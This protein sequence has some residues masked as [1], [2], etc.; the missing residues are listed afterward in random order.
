MESQ[1][2]QPNQPN[3]IS[4]VERRIINE[5]KNAGL[6]DSYDINFIYQANKINVQIRKKD[7]PT[8][9]YTFVLDS[10]YPFVPPQNLYLNGVSFWTMIKIPSERFRSLLKKITGKECL[11]C[12]SLMCSHIWNNQKT[13]LLVIEEI[14]K[15]A[16]IK[17]QIVEKIIGDLIK[18]KFLCEDIPIDQFIY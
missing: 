2:N 16:L 3:Q 10:S 18:K 17:R 9:Q 15:I 1:I 8:K 12:F 4:R 5:F 13:L 11:C 6:L 7:V 14:E